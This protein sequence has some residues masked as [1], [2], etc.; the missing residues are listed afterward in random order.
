MWG[1]V[2]SLVGTIVS[3]IVAAFVALKNRAGA[4]EKSALDARFVQAETE[5]RERMAGENALRE[6]IHKAELKDAVMEGDLKVVQ[7][8]HSKLEG[9]V[10]EIK[11]TMVRRDEWEAQMR[12][13]N[14]RLTTLDEHVQD[15][16]RG[17]SA[18]VAPP[19]PRRRR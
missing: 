12:A 10:E 17:K 6:A 15:A 4:A 16:L 8:T 13:L 3:L 18:S 5:L 11:R 1:P 9:D 14:E 19:R 2:L 7:A